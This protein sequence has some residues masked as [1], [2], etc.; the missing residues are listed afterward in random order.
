MIEPWA[1]QQRQAIRAFRTAI[2]VRAAREREFADESQTRQQAA[3]KRHAGDKERVE[4]EYAA[5]HADALDR[6][7]RSRLEL[8]E[9]HE[10][11]REQLQREY[12]RGKDKNR[13]D[14]R[15]EKEKM[16]A[17]FR[18]SRWT[19]G[20]I[21]ESDKRAAKDQMMEKVI[22][23]KDLVRKIISDWR[24]ARKLIEPLDFID[25]IQ[26]L[27]PAEIQVGDDD[28][29]A[30]MQQCA[31]RVAA[32]LA[33][34]QTLRAPSFLNGRLPWFLLFIVW[35]ILSAP[36]YPW[37][38]DFWYYWLASASLVVPIGYAYITHL[39]R[40][41]N[42]QII[43][44]WLTLRHDAHLARMLRP[45][46]LR[47]AK[48]TY[49][50]KKRQSLKRYRELMRAIVETARAKLSDLRAERDRIARSHEKTFKKRFAE[51]DTQHQRELAEVDEALARD[52][53]EARN[54]HEAELDRM[55]AIYKQ[56][57][58]E[59]H[60]WRTEHWTSLLRDWKA[61]CDRFMQT[62]RGVAKE[63][64]RW[65]P[66][67]A[68]P[69]TLPT[70]LPSGL[71]LGAMQWALEMFPDGVPADV[72]MPRPDLAK[73]SVP[74]LLSFP[75][76]ASLLFRAF[77]DGK[78]SAISTMEAILL[79][80]WTALPPGKVRCTIIDP[81]GRGENF[82]GFMH[83]AD[84]DEKL[85]DYRIWT[86]ASQIDERLSHLTAHMENVLQKYLRNQFE[87]L[88]E[89]NAQA[90]EV[91]EPFHFL[92][93]AHFPVNFNDETARRLVSLA[94]SG[95]R[96]GIYTFV[97]VDTKLAMPH[98]FNIADLE[99]VCTLLN[100]EKGG[101]TRSGRF[102]W[103]D[104]D[105]GMF[106]L[107]L[108]KSPPPDRC[109]SLLR[110][111][112]EESVRASKVEV[113]FEWIMPSRETWWTS[114]TAHGIRVP[115]GRFGAQGKQFLELGQGT[116]QHVLIAGKTGSGKSTL[117]HVLIS[118]LA[119]FYS[120]SEV[121]LY[122]VD[123]KKG[124]E[125]KAYASLAL[126]HAR[127]IAVE[128]EREFGLSVLQRLDAELTKRGELFR[129]AGVN[130]LAGY[131]SYAAAHPD[132][133]AMPRVVLIVDEFQEFFIEDDK[134]AQEASL[135]L[136]RL[137][138][139][140]RAFG[141]HVL[142]GSQT[143]G[144]AYSL[145]RSTID[146]MAVRI[147]LQ[148]SEA[149][150]HLILSRDNTEAQLLS[151][152]GEGIYNPMHG[153]LEGNHL[154]QVVWLNDTK[155]D[156]VLKQ[157]RDLSRQREDFLTPIVFEGSAPADMTTNH[158]LRKV[159]YDAEKPTAAWHA[160]LG[161][162]VAIKDPTAAVFRKQSGANL[163]LL[164][165]QED[166]AVAMTMSALVSLSAMVQANGSQ[167]INLVIGQA[168]DARSE[169]IIRQLAEILPIRLWLPRDL[170]TV[171]GQLADEIDR[172]SDG[173]G[174]PQF[175]MLYGIQR[176]R[177]L[178]RP[179]D[180]FGFSKKGDEKTP[181][182]LFTQIIKDGPPVGTFTLLW[183]DT[184]VNL[185]R[186]IDR[187]TMREF[188]Q[189]VLMQMSAADSSTLMDNPAAAKLGP[190]RALFCTEDLGKIEKFRPYALP[191]LAWIESMQAR[192]ARSV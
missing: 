17:E 86:E 57:R 188:D 158:L 63:A 109:T 159:W 192:R 31:D 51:L 8:R 185:Q 67:L 24:E 45:I 190:Q 81:I 18:D 123:F 100:W 187:Q 92:I 4:Q 78:P 178:R 46:C 87:T 32:D 128:S 145:A 61:A 183:S 52:Q 167:P 126:P 113:P 151:R 99:N 161:D 164:G 29:W 56:T 22:A 85:V 1:D 111:V 44:L 74:A 98:G 50:T 88:A 169:E 102:A 39:R 122:L 33:A 26:P 94:S 103:E 148:C 134:L 179:D 143:I 114:N 64:E 38:F 59:N 20:T 60:R 153:L 7:E 49:L 37:L 118:Q 9:R 156:D 12:D 47:Q 3:E 73:L 157:V 133:L 166:L 2:S 163:L 115:I 54:L 65:F 41:V 112:G 141:M 19:T 58:E 43:A 83:L 152:P 147:A 90:G 132:S 5:A 75:Q 104:D 70:T 42:D 191:E 97:M 116:S 120:P 165:Q 139:Q 138:R 21:Y 27:D 184:L 14:Y 55:E 177:D 155:R 136:D 80:V 6:A 79:R 181:Y 89:Y 149:D 171:L 173:S 30:R 84:H 105:F 36:G 130:D 140:G 10:R 71:P 146:Q 137:V 35:I 48:K 107:A 144:G 25:D 142:L 15:A 66:P 13:E 108:E 62:C 162:A 72:Q 16:E 186:C 11:E 34:L 160:W 124:V 127:V 82:S 110:Q 28:P 172:R 182:R 180:D 96:C 119:M 170:G 23:C 77:D 125:F 189:R 175:L 93:V 95:A 150:A 106:P 154:F 168:L 69:L 117:L 121:E 40:K 131:R 176:L 68:R 76:R 135:L 53:L 91:A 129:I 174:Q 101:D